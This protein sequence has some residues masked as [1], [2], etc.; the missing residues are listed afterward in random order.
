[1]QVNVYVK[2]TKDRVQIKKL[3]RQKHGFIF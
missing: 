3:I 2:F 1:M